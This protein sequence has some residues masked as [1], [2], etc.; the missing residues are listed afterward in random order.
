M[1]ALLLLNSVGVFFVAFLGIWRPTE[2]AIKR[3]YVWVPIP[4]L[5]LGAVSIVYPDTGTSL[6]ED[7]LLGT[8]VGLDEVGR[9]FF[10][11][12]SI[13]W[14]LAGIY[15]KNLFADTARERL[16]RF[17]FLITYSGCLGLTIVQDAPSFYAGYALMT[18]GGYGL[19]INT[20]TRAALLAG[21]VYIV[22]AL[23]GEMLTLAGIIMAAS[24]ARDLSMNEIA[25]GLRTSPTREWSFWLIFLGF[26]TKV[27]IVPLHFWLPR[28]YYWAPL[29]AVAV[30]SGAMT[31][32]GVLGWF[33]FLHAFESNS[34]AMVVMAF[35]TLMAFYGVIFGLVQTRAKTTLAFSSLSQMG[36]LTIA[37]ATVIE[38]GASVRNGLSAMVAFAFHHGLTKTSLFL[39]LGRL[40]GV[41]RGSNEH[42]LIFSALVICALALIGF[43]FTAGAYVKAVLKHAGAAA[44]LWSLTSGPIMIAGAIGTTVLMLRFLVLCYRGEKDQVQ[45]ARE[46]VAWAVSFFMVVSGSWLLPFFLSALGFEVLGSFSAREQWES[47]MPVAIGSLFASLLAFRVWWKHAEMTPRP[48]DTIFQEVY[49]DVWEDFPRELNL[50]IRIASRLLLRLKLRF[51]FGQKAR[52]V[53]AFAQGLRTEWLMG[54]ALFAVIGLLLWGFL[55][56][57]PR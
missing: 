41:R 20:K 19:V 30:L 36:Y 1:N 33:R 21:R 15:S 6:Y 28:S 49:K 32:A 42:S 3:V 4:A 50:F 5:I 27:G 34:A 16:F 7:L 48:F 8:R 17:Y 18:I 47:F 22:I 52:R 11:L 14:L 25:A 40:A 46:G 12:T 9:S 56:G 23:I 51:G 29:P 26:G 2:D 54:C 13:V 35:G 39:G 10:I 55:M 31:K 24:S 44:G 53:V 38:P 43:P 57:E 45:A 37:L